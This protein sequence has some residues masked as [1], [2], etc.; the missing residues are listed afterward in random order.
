MAVR[1]LSVGH[2]VETRDAEFLRTADFAAEIAGLAVDISIRPLSENQNEYG[3]HQRHVK[4]DRD[5]CKDSRGLG[6]SL[7]SP[8]EETACF[9]ETLLFQCRKLITF[10]EKGTR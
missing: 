2:A 9:S 5:Q 10:R 4:R 3:S 1:E 7:K 6:N 8:D